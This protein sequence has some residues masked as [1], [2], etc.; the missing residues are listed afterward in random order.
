MFEA[1]RLKTGSAT[2]LAA[3]AR[4]APLVI[5]IGIDLWDITTS[6]SLKYLESKTVSVGFCFDT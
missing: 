6:T 1:S 3:L 5:P 4:M 2:A